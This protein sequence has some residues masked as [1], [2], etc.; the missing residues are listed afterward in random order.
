MVTVRESR[1]GGD[2]TSVKAAIDAGETDI[3]IDLDW[4]EVED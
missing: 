3:D 2:Y 4:D 1:C